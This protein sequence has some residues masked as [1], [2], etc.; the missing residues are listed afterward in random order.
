MFIKWLC[1]RM[2]DY[3]QIQHSNRYTFKLYDSLKLWHKTISTEGR[4][5][6]YLNCLDAVPIYCYYYG[7]SFVDIISLH[8]LD[9]VNR[10]I[11]GRP[12]ETQEMESYYTVLLWNKLNKIMLELK[13][14]MCLRVFPNIRSHEHL[15]TST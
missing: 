5:R 9:T 13:G 15:K 4:R 8:L 6:T 2:L 12:S 14:H 7:S 3:K 11:H 1:I 10:L